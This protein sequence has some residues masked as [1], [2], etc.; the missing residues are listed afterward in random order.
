MAALLVKATGIWLIIVP[1]AIGNAAVREKLLAP[2]IGSAAALPLSGLLLSAL[3]LLVAYGCV[4][5]FSA[6]E[7]KAYVL[8]GVVWF[9]LTLAFEFLFGR[10]VAGKPWQEIL[11]VFNITDGDL[12]VVVL[13]ATLLSP[14]LAAKLRGL[15]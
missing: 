5:L 11:Q 9:T 1:V 6:S 2:A 14:F 7:S 12:F 4:P 10:F 3:V 15:I 13:L 8:V